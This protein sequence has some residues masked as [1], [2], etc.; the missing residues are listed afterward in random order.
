MNTVVIFLVGV[1]VGDLV[2]LMTIALLSAADERK[3][4]INMDDSAKDEAAV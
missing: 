4:K 1:F 3:H 2:A